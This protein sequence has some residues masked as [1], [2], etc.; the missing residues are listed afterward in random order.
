MGP[1][2]GNPLRS[3]S[4]ARGPA[5]F[6]KIILPSAIEDKKL[7]IPQK[8][9]SEF[10]NKLSSVVTITGPN[11]RVWKMELEKSN[12]EIWFRDDWHEFVNYYSISYYYFLVFRYE[13]NSN[14][15]VSLIFD[16]TATEIHYPCHGQSTDEGPDLD[17]ECTE[18]H[19]RKM[20]EEVLI[21]ISDSASQRSSQNSPESRDVKES[22]SNPTLGKCCN[23]MSQNNL[24]MSKSVTATL[25]NQQSC[26]CFLSRS[27]RAQASL[28]D[29]EQNMYTR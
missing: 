13:G 20:E 27:Q 11:G 16:P 18:Y 10:G 7:R 26:K 25:P 6:F 17:N 1:C 23:F 29:K 24:N 14:F 8:F 21:E 19:E 3:D 2:I 28:Q 22:L 12:N 9:V 4:T 15:H 5:H